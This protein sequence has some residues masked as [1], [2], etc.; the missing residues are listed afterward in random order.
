M[1]TES[2]LLERLG[3]DSTV[4]IAFD[5]RASSDGRLVVFHVLRRVPRSRTLHHSLI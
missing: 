5:V 4:V 3:L 1:I 2:A